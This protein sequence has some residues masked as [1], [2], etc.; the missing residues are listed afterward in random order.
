MTKVEQ[1]CRWHMYL[2]SVGKRVWSDKI[3]EQKMESIG[4]PLI[5][6]EDITEGEMVDALDWYKESNR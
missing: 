3:W 6:V 2:V 1:E 4:N 5:R